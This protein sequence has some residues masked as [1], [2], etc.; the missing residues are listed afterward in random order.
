MN[1]TNRAKWN[2]RVSNRSTL[3]NVDPYI[4]LL[5][6]RRFRYRQLRLRSL[7]KL[8]KGW[9]IALHPVT[10][11]THSLV[12]Q[13]WKVQLSRKIRTLTILFH[14]IELHKGLQIIRNTREQSEILPNSILDSYS[15]ICNLV[16]YYHIL[17]HNSLPS[18]S[19]PVNRNAIPS[20]HPSHPTHLIV[21][22]KAKYI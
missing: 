13:L 20:N 9:K 6:D 14:N 22:N 15:K 16:S 4:T 18:K 17:R 19:Q 2:R 5:R 8:S 7:W 1:E 21:E 10:W 3:H 12:F 11:S